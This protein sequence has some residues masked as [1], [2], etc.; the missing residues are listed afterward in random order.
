MVR[1]S[2]LW[3]HAL[4][5]VTVLGLS[6]CQ[7]TSNVGSGSWK[8]LGDSANKNVKHEI[9]T[10]S[11]KKEGNVVTYRTRTIINDIRLESLPNVPVFKTA[12]STYQMQCR[13]RSYR[14]VD[15]ELYKIG[16]AHV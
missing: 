11:I 10:Q 15:T 5:A 7:T 9:D 1:K 3:A 13:E 8:A 12:I 2:K 14:I 16:R 4:A 6:A